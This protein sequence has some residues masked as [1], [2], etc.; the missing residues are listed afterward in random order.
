MKKY[1]IEFIDT[2]GKSFEVEFETANIEKTVKDYCRNKTIST[3]KTI[4][5]TV[6]NQK[7]ILLG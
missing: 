3:H 1:T 4:E 7:S 2:E 5:E 6:I